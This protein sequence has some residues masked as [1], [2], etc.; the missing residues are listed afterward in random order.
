MGQLSALSSNMGLCPDCATG[1]VFAGVTAVSVVQGHV[2]GFSPHPHKHTNII[3]EIPSRLLHG[4]KKKRCLLA[5]AADF[6]PGS[7]CK[8]G[9]FWRCWVAVA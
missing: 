3:S 8:G 7:C 1:G 6:K 2:K 9:M 5:H 4:S